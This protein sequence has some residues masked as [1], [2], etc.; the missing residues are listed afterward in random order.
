VFTDCPTL[1]RVQ[2]C[3]VCQIVRGERSRELPLI[4]RF[5][6]TVQSDSASLTYRGKHLAHDRENAGIFMAIL[7]EQRLIL[8]E[9]AVRPQAPPG[10]AFT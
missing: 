2:E 9:N 4:G 1:K 7:S 5:W 10:A 8:G 6:G 3:H